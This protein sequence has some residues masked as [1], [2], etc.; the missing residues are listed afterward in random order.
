MEQRLNPEYLSPGL[1]ERAVAVALVTVGIGIGAALVAWG[2][3]A[4]QDSHASVTHERP[5]AVAQPEPAKTLSTEGKVGAQEKS[6]T[7]EVIKRE[8]T[9]FSNV[10]H[11][12]GTVTTGWIYRDGTGQVPM[13]QYCYFSAPNADRSIV[14]VDIAS[15]RKRLPNVNT[16]VVPDVENALAK[17]QWWN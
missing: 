7:G 8:V 17:C 9:V 12:G 2:L 15:D 10:K 1:I 16:L 3:R 11:R 5:I 4:M 13:K 6:S 14:R